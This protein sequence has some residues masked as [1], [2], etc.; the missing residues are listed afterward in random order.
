MKTLF[1]GTDSQ[2]AKDICERG[3]DLSIGADYVDFG[4]GFYLTESFDRAR[5]WA[6]RKAQTR[7]RSPAIVTAV[8]DDVAARDI[9]ETFQDDLRWGRFIVNNRNGIKYISMVP[10][11]E[12]NLDARYDI[13]FGRV[14]DID[15][16]NVAKQLMKNGRMLMSID[17]IFNKDY[18][19]QYV[20]HTERAKTYIIKL[21]YR[22][23]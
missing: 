7:R 2:S 16:H 1:H 23:L 17:G 9:I 15:I 19:M 11:K 22:N 18:P 8:F 4:P 3:I 14:A 6:M 13:T 20:L 12:N 5:I 21:S 10:F